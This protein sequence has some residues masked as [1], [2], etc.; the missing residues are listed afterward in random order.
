MQA[1]Q[2]DILIIGAGPAG[3]VAGSMAHQQGKKVMV[4]EKQ[5]FPRFVIG[6]SLLPSSMNHFEKAKFWEAI[7]SHGFEKKFGAKFVRGKQEC[8]FDFSDTY[9]PGWT[10]TY[11]VPRGDFDKVLAD[12]LEKMGVPIAYNTEV[13][14]VKF[15]GTDSVTTIKNPDGTI[16][17]I[18]AKFLIDASGYGR[19]LP[20][21]FD[22]DEPSNLAPRRAYFVH[23]TDTVRPEGRAGVQ[24]TFYILEREVWLWVIPFANGNTSL[25]FVGAPEFFEPFEAG[26]PT[27]EVFRELLN[28]RPDIAE[29]FK[30]QSFLWE[31]KGITNYAVSTKTMIGN[32]FALAG[33]ATEFLDPVFS[34]GV[35]FATESGSRAATLAVRQLNGETI[36]WKTEYEDHMWKGIN[37]FRSYVKGWYDGV[38]Q[39][40]FFADVYNKD[41][42]K[43]LCSILA[44]YVWD[45]TN[46]FVRRHETAL[47]TVWS[48]I[49]L[50]LRYRK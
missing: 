4:I 46:P 36:D 7:E 2:T 12:T 29:R 8:L 22:L 15:N 26:Q 14:D 42:K 41:I 5:Q 34:S 3:T 25:G 43:Q 40:I 35:G 44:G 28:L 33:N 21:L 45:T 38:L 13:M 1:I 20:R 47:Q 11:Q 17:E 10:Y 32:G 18:E 39:E 19:V 23:A 6:E 31:P 50:E 9:T 24:I 30:D 48:A 49:E 16:S 27:D 37:A